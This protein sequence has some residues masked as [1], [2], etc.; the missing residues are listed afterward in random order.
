[1]AH[2]CFQGDWDA[3]EA[4]WWSALAEFADHPAAHG[5]TRA[6]IMG[7]LENLAVLEQSRTGSQE[8]S[9][10]PR[11]WHGKGSDLQEQIPKESTLEGLAP[12]Q[13]Q[14][15]DGPSSAHDGVEL[16]A[17]QLDGNSC[18]SIIALF[19][20]SEDEYYKGN[21]IDH[22][23]KVI[24]NETVKK[25]IELDISRSEQP[26]WRKWDQTL[27][28]VVVAVVNKYEVEYPGY[29]FLPNPLWDEG[30]RIKRYDPPDGVIKAGHHHW[31]VD[32]SGLGCR[33]LAVLIYL[34]DVPGGGGETLFRTP[35][36]RAIVP[37]EGSVLVFPTSPS[38]LHAGAPPVGGP[39]FVISNFVATC[40]LTER[41]DFGH[42]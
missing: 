26:E 5:S 10:G 20:S 18:K 9:S 25:S 38:Y 11:I 1:M 19:E 27:L 42:R 31:H 3:A 21:T 39:K 35:Y 14:V 32:Q 2:C 41:L 17:S 16:Y 24:V 34:A 29:T 12:F 23:G 4:C 36:P 40:N 37:R 7:V 15:Q 8:S 22:H 6:N 13:A 33:Q 28:Q 30:F